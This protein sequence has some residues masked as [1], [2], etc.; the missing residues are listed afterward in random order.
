MLL[1]HDSLELRLVLSSA[2]WIIVT[3]AATCVLVVYLFHGHIKKRFENQLIDHLEEL[4]AASDIDQSGQLTLSWTPADTRFR[5]PQSGWYWLI[6]SAG[7]DNIL[8]RSSSSGT[9]AFELPSRNI[10][11]SSRFF[12]GQ[13]PQ[14]QTLYMYERIIGL[15]RAHQPYIFLAAGP[16][17][18]ITSDVYRFSYRLAFIL[19]ILAIFLLGLVWFQIFFGLRPLRRIQLALSDI[20]SGNKKRLP[21]DFPMEVRPLVTELNSLLDFNKALLE[22]ARTQV[23]NLAHALKNPLAVLA[24]EVEGMNGEC[25]NIMRHQLRVAIDSVNYHLH[26]ARIAGATNV[27]G[28]VSDLNRVAEDLKF[29]LGVLYKNREIDIRLNQLDGIS[30]R[31]DTEDLEE[32]LGN[33]LDNACKWARH[34]VTVDVVACKQDIIIVIEDDGPGIP[35]SYRE[36]VIRRGIRHDEMQAGS[37]LGLSIV[38]TIVGLYSGTLTLG[39]AG[40]GG[41]RAELRLPVT[42]QKPE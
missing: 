13:G 20:R 33:L 15:P 3:L 21:D 35:S 28:A 25:G 18:D 30:V 1:R 32:M 27:L 42:R 9:F 14:G 12:Q 10:E 8:H 37:G 31:V 40:T 19:S 39:E 5:R 41:L 11:M 6:L 2:L 26:K 16:I 29:S 4:V 34:T 17:S 22:R 24:N 38:N 7:T 23:G 36:E